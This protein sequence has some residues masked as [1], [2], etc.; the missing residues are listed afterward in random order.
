MGR[1][2]TVTKGT[3]VDSFTYTDW[4]AIASAKRGTSGNLDLVSEVTRSYN[5]L[6]RLTRESQA[7]E[8]A[9]ARHVDYT[10]DDGGNVLTLDYPGG[11]TIATT[12]DSNNRRDVI[13]KD[14]SQIADYDYIGQRVDSL[15]FETGANDITQGHAYDGA[16]RL[17]ELSQA[18]TV[19]QAPWPAEVREGSAGWGEGFSWR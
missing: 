5:G 6:M 7:I 4:G 10:Y 8:E 16:A 19:R 14:G 9:T 1:K 13:S 3:E 11:T 15:I 2:L 18:V 12:F 17:T